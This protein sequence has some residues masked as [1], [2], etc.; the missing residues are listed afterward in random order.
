MVD[1]VITLFQASV[2]SA[3]MESADCLMIVG[4]FNDRCQSWEGSHNTSDLGKK[5]L[6]LTNLLNIFQ[7]ISEP[8]RY[9][10]QIHQLSG[11]II[12]T[13]SPGLVNNLA[14]TPP[15]SDLDPYAIYCSVDFH[16]LINNVFY[17]K[18]WDYNQANY[19]GLNDSLNAQLINWENQ[20]G[21]DI[22]Q[23]AMILNTIITENADMYITNRIIKIR[24]RD[25]PYMTHSCRIADRDRDRWHKQIQRTKQQHH[26]DIFREKRRFAKKLPR[27]NISFV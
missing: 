1:N 8:T 15:I 22:Q 27:M 24:T 12:L 13:D 2:V 4:D 7:V 18:G 3:M 21:Q 11:D 19:E 9:T 14:V 23:N 17:R 5:L 20:M 6:D 16:Y 10:E 25:K 26:Y